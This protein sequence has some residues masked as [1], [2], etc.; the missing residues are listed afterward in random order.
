MK[1]KIWCIVRE[2]QFRMTEISL[3]LLLCKKSAFKTFVVILRKF[4]SILL[5]N[6]SLFGKKEMQFRSWSFESDES[7]T[8]L[9]MFKAGVYFG[10]FQAWR[11][12][13]DKNKLVRLGSKR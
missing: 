2:I 4:G 3:Q 7:S 10:K 13:V 5:W 12:D 8:A 1:S 9:E 6:E 11:L